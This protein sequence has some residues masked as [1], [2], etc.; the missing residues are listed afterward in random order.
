M[1][2]THMREKALEGKTTGQPI[3][4]VV[5]KAF[6]LALNVDSQDTSDVSAEAEEK[7]LRHIADADSYEQLKN[8]VLFL[9]TKMITVILEQNSSTY[10]CKY[11]TLM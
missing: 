4:R 3:G 6:K 10:R 2:L 11:L 9:T 8:P 1:T 7:D 5:Q